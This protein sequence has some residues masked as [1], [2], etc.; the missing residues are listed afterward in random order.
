MTKQVSVNNKKRNLE[1]YFDRCIEHISD[2]YR[3]EANLFFLEE[4][5]YLQH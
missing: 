2:H 4:K 3:K 1:E 5:N